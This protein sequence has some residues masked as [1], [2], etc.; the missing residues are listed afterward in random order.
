MSDIIQPEVFKNNNDSLQEISL[1][2]RSIQLITLQRG[3]DRS[4]HPVDQN[5]IV[6]NIK[7]V[8]IMGAI[9]IKDHPYQKNPIKAMV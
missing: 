5:G 7:G 4:K 9:V 1:K 6:I 2:S 3:R 8:C